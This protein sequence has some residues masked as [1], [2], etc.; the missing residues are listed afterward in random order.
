M[1]GQWCPTGCFVREKPKIKLDFSEK[2]LGLVQS[3]LV[4]IF[5]ILALK[6]GHLHC[7]EKL[8]SLSSLTCKSGLCV[9][10]STHAGGRQAGGRSPCTRECHP[11]TAHP[12][13]PAHRLP[14]AHLTG[15]SCERLLSCQATATSHSVHRQTLTL[16]LNAHLLIIYDLGRRR[17]SPRES[18]VKKTPRRE[19][20]V[21]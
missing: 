13:S 2:A 17:S 5:L 12:R 1:I 8:K 21:K 11:G 3:S 4:F 20:H 15:L 14:S 7:Q 6:R 9:R 16:K 10:V 19:R 18:Q